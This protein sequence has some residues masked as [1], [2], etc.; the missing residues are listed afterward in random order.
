MKIIFLDELKCDRFIYVSWDG[1]YNAVDSLVLDR[2]FASRLRVEDGES[3]IVQTLSKSDSE[4]CTPC[5]VCHV[6]PFNDQDYQLLTGNADEVE[7]GVLNQLRVITT[8]SL[9]ESPAYFNVYPIW[10]KSSQA[11]RPVFVQFCQVE[12]KNEH[13]VVL[14]QSTKLIVLEPSEQI[15]DSSSTSETSPQQH[16]SGSIR[17]T[18]A[19]LLR[20][21]I[22]KS[23]TLT[24]TWHVNEEKLASPVS[25]KE[26]CKSLPV[27]EGKPCMLRVLPYTFESTTQL[28]TAGYHTALVSSVHFRNTREKCLLVRLNKLKSARK[29]REQKKTQSEQKEHTWDT[30][31]LPQDVAFYTKLVDQWLKDFDGKHNELNVL[32]FGDD[33]CPPD[34]IVLNEVLRVQHSLAAAD[35]VQMCS[36]LDDHD[37]IGLNKVTRVEKTSF[38]VVPVAESIILCPLAIHQLPSNQIDAAKLKTELSETLNAAATGTGN[39][40]ILSKCLLISNGFILKL[41]SLNFFAYYIHPNAEKCD[42]HQLLNCTFVID[43]ATQLIVKSITIKHDLTRLLATL[44]K[45]V[46]QL[47]REHLPL[48]NDNTILDRPFGGFAPLFDNLVASIGTQF[49]AATTLPNILICGSKGAGKSTLV[50]RLMYYFTVNQYVHCQHNQCAHLKGKRIESL[51]KA[52]TELTQEAIQHA[53]SLLVFE[54][55]D[56]LSPFVEAGE[57]GPTP[58]EGQMPEEIYSQ[59]IAHLFVHLCQ[60]IRDSGSK[61][62]VLATSKSTT[63]LHSYLQSAVFHEVFDIAP[64]T[65]RQRALIVEDVIKKKNLSLGEQIIGVNMLFEMKDLCRATKNFRPEDL[66]QLMDVA[67]HSALVTTLSKSDDD[68]IDQLDLTQADIEHALAVYSPAHLATLKLEIDSVRTLADVGGLHSVKNILLDTILLPVRHPRLFAQLPLKPAN[69]VLLYGMPG[70]GKTILVEAIAHE[71]GLNF[72]GVKGPELLS[73]YIG[74]SEQSVRDLFARAQ[75][76]APCLLFFDEFDSLAPRRGH[77]ST[78]VTDRIVNQM[79]TLLD[80]L[81]EMRRDVYILAA[82][83]RPDLIDLALLRPGRFDRCLQ[84]DLPDEQDRLEIL[85]S[86]TKHVSLEPEVELKELATRTDNF[87]GAD[88]QAFVYNA[89]LVALK[90]T[91]QDAETTEAVEPKISNEHFEQALQGT[92]PSLSDH[93]QARFRTM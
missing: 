76:A 25:N 48:L 50:K 38:A 43:G 74:A 65:S 88:L 86:L 8:T 52:W 11:S 1:R 92:R 28:K 24:T 18:L 57:H 55:L 91:P 53:P 64:P 30:A 41:G 20:T 67:L 51:K 7:E 93:E 26:Q 73:K 85:S 75:T 42:L 31:S 71:S 60:L 27:F 2:S 5:L 45:D 89:Y 87:T 61:V 47:D 78:G 14:V 81:E 39:Q 79:L 40:M 83:S 34:S 44:A 12:P 80:G 37:R 54:D 70:T 17:S 9:D 19:S 16:D 69:S 68:N 82:T 72:I 36:L 21:V 23:T 3:V 4:K 56:Q 6:R 29:I 13:C 62:V 46:R 77:D 10:L 22:P 32:V 35:Y 63:T 66:C 33:N 84:C 90:C 58:G 49:N 15:G 59:R